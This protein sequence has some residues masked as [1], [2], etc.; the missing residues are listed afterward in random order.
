MPATR[1]IP[2]SLSVAGLKMT[3]VGTCRSPTSAS[4]RP[5]WTDADPVLERLLDRQRSPSACQHSA[6][7]RE[8]DATL[9]QLKTK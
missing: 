8:S 1:T 5:C 3:A 4:A 9:C 2:L 6:E 7:H